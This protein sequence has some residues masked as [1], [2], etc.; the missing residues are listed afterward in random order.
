MAAHHPVRTESLLEVEDLPDN[1]CDFP[2]HPK[3]FLINNVLKLIKD[4]KAI[5]EVLTRKEGRFTDRFFITIASSV[6]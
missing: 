3:I 1:L 5:Y 4:V 6:T 2:I